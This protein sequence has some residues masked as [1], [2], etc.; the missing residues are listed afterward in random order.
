[1][2]DEFKGKGVAYFAPP[3]T[4]TPKRHPTASLEQHGREAGLSR[5]V[6]TGITPDGSG[7]VKPVGT[8]RRAC[9]SQHPLALLIFD[10]TR[11]RGGTDYWGT[12]GFDVRIGEDSMGKVD[13]STI[14]R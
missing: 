11:G 5:R 2:P 1:M 9:S 7:D 6:V 12:E 14:V 10:L 4:R 8:T 13:S 3:S